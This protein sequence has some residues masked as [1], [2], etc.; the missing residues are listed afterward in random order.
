MVLRGGRMTIRKQKF[1]AMRVFRRSGIKN[2]L[3]QDYTSAPISHKE[4]MDFLRL[5]A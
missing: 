1:L 2:Q 5:R 4:Y 3:E